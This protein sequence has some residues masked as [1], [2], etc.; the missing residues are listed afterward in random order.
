MLP[1]PHRLSHLI[2][3]FRVRAWRAS[4]ISRNLTSQGRRGM[5]ISKAVPRRPPPGSRAP[6]GPVPDLGC[7]GRPWA[8]RLPAEPERPRQLE[9]SPALPHHSS[10]P[11]RS[12]MP[13]APQAQLSA[14]LQSLWKMLLIRK[15]FKSLRT[16]MKNT[17]VPTTQIKQMLTFCHMFQNSRSLSKAVK[18]RIQSPPPLGTPC[19]HLLTVLTAPLGWLLRTPQAASCFLRTGVCP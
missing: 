17:H 16:D 7:C 19:P 3:A 11:S 12:K 13:P 2:A 9:P 4:A 15:Y 10:V 8:E 5:N 6:F 14:L 1:A 18:H